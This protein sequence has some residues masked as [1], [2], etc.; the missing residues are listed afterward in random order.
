[1][2]PCLQLSTWLFWQTVFGKTVFG[3]TV[4]KRALCGFWRAASCKLRIG[5][6]KRQKRKKRKKRRGKQQTEQRA[7]LYLPVT[8]LQF[9]KQSKLV[10]ACWPATCCSLESARRAHKSKRCSSA[11]RAAHPKLWK[12]QTGRSLAFLL[13]KSSPLALHFHCT[14]ALH[15]HWT[16]TELTLH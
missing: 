12:L 10:E 15:L 4:A 2:L 14:V 16:C 6:R 3:Q 13:P 7:A 8:E 5:Q 11:R 1:M 9:G